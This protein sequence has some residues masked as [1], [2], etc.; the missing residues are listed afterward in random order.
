[1]EAIVDER[2]RVIGV[3]AVDREGVVHRITAKV[4]VDATGR[5][6]LV[7][8]HKRTRHRVPGL[9]KTAIFTQFRGGFR[10]PGDDA[11]QIEIL[12][13]DHAEAR[14]AGQTAGWGWYIPFKDGRSSAGFVLPT[15][16]LRTGFEGLPISHAR[17]DVAAGAGTDEL[18]TRAQADSTSE[19]LEPTYRALVAR[20]PW[21]Q[22]L[23]EGTTRLEPVRA[24]ADY[25]FR[26]SEVAGDGW[27]A[28]G[29]AG[30][31]LDPLFSSGANLA[32]AGAVRGAEGSDA[33]LVA[34]DVSRARFDRYDRDV[35]AAA[36]LFLGPV[37][38]FY[39]GELQTYLFAEKP[40][41][42]VRKMITT[43]LAGDVFPR[44]KDEARW[45]PFFRER[46]PATL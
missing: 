13:L 32:L 8:K 44:S 1:R 39:R 11:G 21:M 33:A 20:S 25:S 45:V 37:Q 31:F 12:V 7:A 42:I 10:N 40:R 35:R 19:R 43:M 29:D 24:A 17:D 38:A 4:V 6:A 22:T 3:V 2:D 16:T 34:G 46:F 5:E 9:D 30:G 23:L 27:I 28:V 36:A 26:V 18:T 14:A 41:E 15:S